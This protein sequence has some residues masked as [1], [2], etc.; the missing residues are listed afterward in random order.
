MAAR[1]GF[2][3][4]GP[5]YKPLLCIKATDP[6][7]HGCVTVGNT[8]WRVTL[9]NI[10]APCEAALR[11]LVRAVS[12]T[13]LCIE[14]CDWVTDLVLDGLDFPDLLVCELNL[15]GVS[16]TALTRFIRRH[17]LP[18]RRIGIR[19]A[20]ES[21]TSGVLDAALDT[22]GHVHLQS[23]NPPP[24]AA[25]QVDRYLKQRQ[26]DRYLKQ[27]C[28][29]HV[30]KYGTDMAPFP[31]SVQVSYPQDG[32]IANW[33][34]GAAEVHKSAKRQLTIELIGARH[35]EPFGLAELVVSYM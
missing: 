7:L 11:R 28:T 27:R 13:E 2:E 6:E 19:V 25:N 32:R 23:R 17:V 34:I 33:D 26:V 16:D 12:V 9:D 3:W 14:G 22:N 21:M 5:S 29:E 30:V 8:G 10:T 4:F 24:C 20:V 18:H 35:L 1:S 15:P 31:W